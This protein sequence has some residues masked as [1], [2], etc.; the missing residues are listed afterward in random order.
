[1]ADWMID[2]MPEEPAKTERELVPEGEHSFEIK[3]ATQ[4]PHKFK[5]GEFLMLRL[6][7]TNGSYQFVF[8]DIPFGASGVRLAKGLAEA[9]GE[10]ATGK[11]SLDPEAL[12]G[13][14]VRAVIYHRTGS[15]GRTYVN[16]SEFKPT[17]TAVKA[18]K[19]AATVAAQDDIPF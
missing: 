12:A 6:S 9:L 10:A 5:E 3:S 15:N 1:M 14:E 13:R 4:G 7:A 19:K 8:C 18:A 11:I 17:K 16:V 2:D